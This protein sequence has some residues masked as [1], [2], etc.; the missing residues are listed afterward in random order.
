MQSSS[1]ATTG[2]EPASPCS[3]TNA[4]QS[5]THIPSPVHAAASMVI[6]RASGT[7][8]SSPPAVCCL[9]VPHPPPV[10]SPLPAGVPRPARPGS[11]GVHVDPGSLPRAGRGYTGKAPQ[12]RT[13]PPRFPPRE[14]AGR[15]AERERA[16]GPFGPRA[17]N[18]PS[19][20]RKSTWSVRRVTRSGAFRR[21]HR[22]GRCAA[23]PR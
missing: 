10:G 22:A 2:V 16:R 8:F 1:R 7:A 12:A 11:L 19:V 3:N 18:H 6:R 14:G 13:N 5:A 20:V 21:R 17:P 4:G 9:D 15:A 23:G